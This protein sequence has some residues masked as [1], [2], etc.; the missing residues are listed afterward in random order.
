MSTFL[1]TGSNRGIGL[2]LC[3]QIN[4]RGDNV[5]ATC[6]KSSPELKSLGVRIEE[7]IDI[8]YSESIVNLRNNL[9]GVELDCLINNAG[10]A[11]YNTFEDLDLSSILHQFKIDTISD[12]DSLIKLWLHYLLLNH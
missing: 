9:A 4:M 11:E 10:I 8:T 12:H 7:N 5:I 3:K 2:E 6:R 1:I